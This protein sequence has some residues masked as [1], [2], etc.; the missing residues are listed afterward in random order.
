[1]KMFWNG[2]VAVLLGL[3][4]V[5][6]GATVGDA[7]T[8]D[9]DCG[10]QGICINNQEYTPGGYCSQSCVPGKDKTCPSGSTCV[11]EAASDDVSACFLLCQRDEDCRSGYRCRGGFK[12]NAA[13]ICVAAF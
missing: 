4:L 13:S 10:S 1:M 3:G 6:C 2:L 12:N 5:G 11:S 9:D 8:T 7:C